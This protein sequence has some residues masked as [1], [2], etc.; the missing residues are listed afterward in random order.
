ML[1]TFTMN[2][3]NQISS[4]MTMIYPPTNKIQVGEII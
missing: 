4:N 1:I 2:V 3:D